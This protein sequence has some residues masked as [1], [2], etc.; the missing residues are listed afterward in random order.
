MPTGQNEIG[1]SRFGQVG[2]KSLHYK[3]TFEGLWAHI[4]I[5]ARYSHEGK[6]KA[7]RRCFAIFA[8]DS[9][10]G[11]YIANRRSRQGYS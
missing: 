7:N 5:L 6:Y 1:C 8:N 9:Q 4:A 3:K 11:K 2:S 10:N